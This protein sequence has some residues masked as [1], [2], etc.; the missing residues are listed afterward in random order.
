ME[1]YKECKYFLT[2]NEEE[3]EWLF[4]IVNNAGQVEDT[5][6]ISADKQLRFRSELMSSLT[7]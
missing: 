7:N 1:H 5:D 4:D 3:A 6:S 2:L